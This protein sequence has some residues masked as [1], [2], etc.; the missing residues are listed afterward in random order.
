MKKTEKTFFVENLTKQIESATSVVLLDY[1]GLTVAKQQDLKNKLALV[2][3]KMVVVK[4]TLF[5]LAGKSANIPEEVT[6]D[7]TLSG[8]TAMVITEK[9]PIN[10]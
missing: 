8:P 1:T 4:N 9:D 7:T 10:A 3:A 2:G 5:K 6:F